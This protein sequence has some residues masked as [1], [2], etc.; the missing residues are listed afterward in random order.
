MNGQGSVA[1]TLLG[2]GEEPDHVLKVGEHVHGVSEEEDFVSLRG[3]LMVLKEHPPQ[4]DRWDHL[5]RLFRGILLISTSASLWTH[6][7]DIHDTANTLEN[8]V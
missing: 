2:K 8:P 4:N 7:E 3:W 6:S 1:E 5:R